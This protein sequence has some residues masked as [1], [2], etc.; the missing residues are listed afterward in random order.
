VVPDPAINAVELFGTRELLDF[1]H[2]NPAVAVI[3]STTCHNPRWLA[4]IPRF[5]SINSAVEIDLTG[6]VGSEVIGGRVISGIGGSVDFFQGAT[7]A[8]G[9]VRV[10]AMQS[11]TPD[12]SISKIVPCLDA[13]TPVTVPRHAV[14]YVVTEHGVA[15]LAGRSL[16]ER[17]EALVAIADPRYRDE[18]AG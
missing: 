10:I 6:Q 3:P 15:R 14:D 9:G 2:E 8:D 17:A 4:T 11:T 16:R 12:G 1:A 18:L 5:V 13:G 7:W